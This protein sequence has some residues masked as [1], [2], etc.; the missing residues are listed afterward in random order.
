VDM[1]R[2]FRFRDKS[3]VLE[4]CRLALP[5]AP[6]ASWRPRDRRDGGDCD[7]FVEMVET[8]SE[9][10]RS[11]GVLEVGDCGGGSSGSVVKPVRPEFAST[12]CWSATPLLDYHQHS[13]RLA[14][15]QG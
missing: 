10:E 13:D 8:D 1:D 6:K 5:L 2:C 11:A 4:R 15:R 9:S 12:S 14:T 7:L 3:G